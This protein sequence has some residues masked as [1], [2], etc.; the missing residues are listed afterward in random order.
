MQSALQKPVSFPLTT[1]KKPSIQHVSFYKKND[2]Y[3]YDNKNVVYLAYVG[4]VNG[5][6]MFK[7]G[8]TS[9]LYERE[10]KAH[11]KNFEFFEMQHVKITDNKDIVEDLFEKELQ[12]RNIHRKIT[13]KSMKQ[14]EL[15]TVTEEY[16]FEYIKK[17]LNRIVK[18]NPSYEVSVLK[19]KLEKLQ[20]EY[21]LLVSQQ[22]KPK[23]RKIISE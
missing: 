1:V 16:D 22:E 17:M 18:N 19:R 3:K 12:M 8:K 23:R 14:T 2:L 11:R 20:S 15:F 21:D 7:Y 6:D 5:E 4:V 13:I 9:Q 10:Y